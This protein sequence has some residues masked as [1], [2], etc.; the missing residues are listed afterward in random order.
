LK[1]LEIE[2]YEHTEENIKKMLLDNLKKKLLQETVTSVFLDQELE[3]DQIDKV[4]K[5]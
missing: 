1:V 4:K 2:N 5:L 3:N